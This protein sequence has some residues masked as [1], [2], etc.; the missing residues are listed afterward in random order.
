MRPTTARRATSARRRQRRL[1]GVRYYDTVCAHL[2]EHA[3]EQ[4]VQRHRHS[5][6]TQRNATQRTAPHT[7]RRLRIVLLCIHTGCDEVR[8]HAEP[9]NA[10][11]HR[12]DMNN[13]TFIESA[14]R[15][16]AGRV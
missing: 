2:T 1:G 9:H 13:G 10:A 4:T 3:P 7:S 8:R 16:T 11:L 14:W 5:A 15:E 12:I 6:H